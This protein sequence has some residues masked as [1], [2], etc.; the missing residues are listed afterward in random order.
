[1]QKEL[2][3]ESWSK[4]WLVVRDAM[5]DTDCGAAHDVSETR[6]ITWNVA[7]AQLVDTT[8]W[9]R[10]WEHVQSNSETA[11]KPPLRALLEKLNPQTD[12]DCEPSSFWLINPYPSAKGMV[13]P[14][15][16]G[17]ARRVCDNEIL[18]PYRTLAPLLTPAGQRA[19]REEIQN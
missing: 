5:L 17:Y 2:A 1:M 19:L 13:F 10:D 12:A 16:H 4:R 8:R 15:S 9:I 7:S 18:V 3:P 14:T 6:Y 11:P